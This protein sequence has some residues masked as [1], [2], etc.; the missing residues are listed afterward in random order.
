LEEIQTGT[1]VK[2]DTMISGLIVA[3][4]IFKACS[5]NDSEADSFLKL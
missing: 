5:A 3:M 4:M 1:I 2:S